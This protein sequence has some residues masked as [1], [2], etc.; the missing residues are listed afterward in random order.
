MQVKGGGH[1]SNPNF[2]SSTG[3]QISMYRLNRIDYD[4]ST[5]TVA[6]GAG[7][8]WDSVYS[9]LEP[10]GVNVVGGRVSGIGVA[11]FTLGGGKDS[12]GS[13]RRNWLINRGTRLFL[14]DEPIWPGVG[15]G[16]W[17]R[18]GFAQRY[19]HRRDGVSV[20]RPILGPEGEIQL[21]KLSY[22]WLT[23]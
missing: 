8:V 10:Y 22:L 16:S 2:S 18:T 21:R 1:A 19:R 17:L 6:V 14:A 20:S 3:V 9:A 11:G 5:G 13:G 4:S 23:L 15:L 7:N 12:T